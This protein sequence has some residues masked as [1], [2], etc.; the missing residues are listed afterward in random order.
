MS[1]PGLPFPLH[2]SESDVSYPGVSIVLSGRNRKKYREPIF[3]EAKVPSVFFFFAHEMRSSVLCWPL[4][5]PCFVPE[6]QI[7]A[8]CETALPLR[9]SPFAHTT[10]TATKDKHPV[11]ARHFAC[12]HYELS[13]IIIEVKK[14]RPKE[15]KQFTSGHPARKLQS[16][17][18][19]PGS[20]AWRLPASQFWWSSSSGIRILWGLETTDCWVLPQKFGFIRVWEFAFLTRSSVMRILLSGNHTLQTSHLSAFFTPICSANC[21]PAFSIQYRFALT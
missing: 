1:L 20:L 8:S 5:T 18:S 6:A 4:V 11:P 17:G 2:F 16:L 9:H 19:D 15:I 21:S 12:N 7:P 14:R 13:A 3:L 10:T